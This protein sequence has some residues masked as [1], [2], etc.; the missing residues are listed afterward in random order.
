MQLIWEH[1]LHLHYLVPES[2]NAMRI[3]HECRAGYLATLQWTRTNVKVLI[4]KK[5]QQA[6]VKFYKNLINHKSSQVT[7]P[8]QSRNN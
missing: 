8:N 7:L 5:N 4:E 6:I 1:N 2:Y 3:V